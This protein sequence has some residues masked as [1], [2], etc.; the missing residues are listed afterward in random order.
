[1]GRIL[2]LRTMGA[3]LLLSVKPPK[4]EFLQSGSEST[5]E[6]VAQVL[7]EVLNVGNTAASA[8]RPVDE[9]VTVTSN[10]SGPTSDNR[11]RIMT[12]ALGILLPIA[13]KQGPRLVKIINRG[14]KPA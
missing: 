2:A 1:M 11:V 9:R 8:G 7:K 14:R 10:P 13:R 6:R 5:P 12:M 3:I 4:R